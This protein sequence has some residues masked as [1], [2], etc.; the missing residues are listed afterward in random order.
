MTLSK[1]GGYAPINIADTS[2]GDL[3][4]PVP[5]YQNLMRKSRTQKQLVKRGEGQ[6][7]ICSLRKSKK[8]INKNG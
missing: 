8:K 1:F 7:P 4:E 3:L 5:K 6:L 2:K